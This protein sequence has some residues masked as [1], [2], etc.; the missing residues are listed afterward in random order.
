MIHKMNEQNWLEVRQ[1]GSI[2]SNSRFVL[3]TSRT[4]ASNCDDF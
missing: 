2:F 1:D 3:V 4:A